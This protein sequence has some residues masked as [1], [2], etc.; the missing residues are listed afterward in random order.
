M[1]APIHSCASR[2]RTTLL[3]TLVIALFAGLVPGAHAATTSNV[4]YVFDFGTGSNDPCAPFSGGACGPFPGSSIFVNSLT[5]VPPLGVYTTADASLTVTITDL[6]VAVIDA[7]PATA[8]LPF[9]TVILY[10]VCDI[11]SH[12]N[13]MMAVNNFLAAG[14][15]VLIFDADRCSGFGGLPPAANY[16]TFLFPFTASTPG[17]QGATGDYTNV[18]PSTL[19]TGLPSAPP[20]VTI[21]AGNDSV[22]D[23]NNFVTFNPNWCGSITAENKL[24]N[25]GFVEA[26]ARTPAGGLVV[27]EG[28]DFWF[29]FGAGTTGGHQR[30]VFDLMLKQAFNPDGLPCALP[31]SGIS[32]APPTQT[33]NV[34]SPATVTAHVVDANNVGQAGITVDFTVASGPN[35]GDTGSAVT[36]GS[37]DAS[38]TITCKAGG[39]NV[40]HASFVDILGNTHFSNDVTVICNTPPVALCK[41]VT[42]STS[43]GM[44]SAVSA[45]VDN[46]SFDPDAGDTITITQ[47]PSG[48]FGLGTTTVTLT[49]TDNHGASAQCQG[50]ITVVDTEPPKISCPAPITT[51]CTGPSGANATVVPSATDNCGAV[52][53]SCSPSSP[54]PLGTTTVTCT[55]TDTAGNQ[56]S[57]NT[58][59][60]VVDTKP[61]VVTCVESVNPAGKNIPPAGTT[62]PGTKGG[63]NPDGFYKVAAT[64]ICDVAPKISLGGVALA[65]GETIKITQSPGQSGVTLLNT[66]GPLAIKHFQVGPGDATITATD[67]SGNT[68]TVTCLVPP[69]PK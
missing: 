5:G 30:L 14:G 27:Y 50:T 52:T 61:P 11:G 37:G 8:L 1:R 69:P 4:A 9:D 23:A 12:P 43:P 22:G 25:I 46:G 55:A 34:G 35:A 48:P 13:T 32:L 18:E 62:L 54:F 20:P 63:Q 49:V 51:E 17:P 10:Q 40:L 47:S 56:S 7:A 38:F 26:Y 53:A 68:G 36:N 16:S 31:A 21:D 44:C 67:A 28:E 42:V 64:D 58:T 59:V 6:P 24:G 57:C 29:D 19:T 60:K 3:L 65:N 45:S 15:K 66:M 2:L 41:N 33:V 39:T